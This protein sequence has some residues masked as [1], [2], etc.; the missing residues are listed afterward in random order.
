L[1]EYYLSSSLF[2]LPSVNEGDHVEGFGLVFLEAAAAGLPVVGTLNNGIADA[3]S[4][5]YNGILV[6]Q[7]NPE[8]TAKAICEILKDENRWQVMS[9]AGISWAGQNDLQKSVEKYVHLYQVL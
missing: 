3:V 7:E 4:N 5:G 2:L 8:A 9:S 1:R 6:P